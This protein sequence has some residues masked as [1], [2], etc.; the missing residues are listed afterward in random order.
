MLDGGYQI[1]VAFSGDGSLMGAVSGSGAVWVFDAATG[2]Q[3]GP[4]RTVPSPPVRSVSASRPTTRR[5]SSPAAAARSPCSTSSGARSWPRPAET[6]GW[7]ATFSPDGTRFAVPIDG[8]DNDTA[9]VDVAT[10]KLLQ[11]LHPA[12]RFPNWGT[13]PHRPFR[14]AFS[15]DGQE[16]AIGSAA[17]DGQPAEIEVFSVADGSSLRR[18]PVPGVPFIG[19]PLAWSPDG[20]VLAG[21]VHNRVVRIDAIDWCSFSRTLPSPT[22]TCRSRWTYDKD[23][24]LAVGGGL[25]GAKAWIFDASGQPIRTYGPQ[26]RT[27]T[28][29]PVWG[30]GGT[31]VLPNIATGEIRLVEPVADR[32]AG[33]S[34]AGPAGSCKRRGRI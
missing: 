28:C 12:R 10:G 14:V 30:P 19:E 16:V 31:L 23:G 1:H 32:Q 18:L 13:R 11:T 7:L 24:K 6:T 29:I 27:R 3:V 15:P 33:P 17:Y 26:P 9:I 21:G 4:D 25:P 5:S 2:E 8:S 22:S 34:F 20:R